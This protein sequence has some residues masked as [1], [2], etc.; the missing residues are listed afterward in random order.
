MDLLKRFW[1]NRLFKLIL[2]IVILLVA[3]RIA[4]PYIILDYANKTLAGL[5]EYTGHI[6][7]IDLHLYRGATE[8]QN[9][10]I[11]KRKGKIPVPFY[12]S[13]SVDF[14]I[15]WKA[16]FDGAVVAKI[17]VT[18]PKINF[19]KG[20]TKVQTQTGPDTSW[21]K[22]VLHMMPL[23]INRFEIYNGEIHYRD[24]TSKPKVD[25]SIQQFN[26]IATN[27]TNSLKISKTFFAN[28]QATGNVLKTGKF[29]LNVN[30][31]P[32]AKAPTF[33]LDAE[34][35]NVNLPDMNDFIKAYGKFDVE[36]GTFGLYTEFAAE[37]GKFD[38]YAKPIF[39]DL[40]VFST[41]E[42][43]DNFLQGV[44]EAIVG[45]VASIFENQPKDQIAT[46]IPMSGSIKDPNTGIWTAVWE[47]VRNA[48]IQALFP[49]IEQRISLKNVENKG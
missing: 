17:S 48:F 19:V 39:K 12:S 6:D 44:W 43:H 29:R 11:L 42:K 41:K 8:I 3:I 37:N 47:L 21:Q 14:S 25:V 31:N 32:Y 15:D 30:Y 45:T 27:L 5:P 1:R 40:E 2:T 49:G 36:K 18:N 28:I 9:I 34:I 46:R 23:S 26:V 35:T 38:G 33:N 4:L 13:E 10:E 24:F 7:D 16:L 22:R 20:P